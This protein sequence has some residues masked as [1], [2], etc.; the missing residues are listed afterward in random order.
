MYKMQVKAVHLRNRDIVYWVFACRILL[1][2]LT[3][4]M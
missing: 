1:T 3:P 2:F 4:V